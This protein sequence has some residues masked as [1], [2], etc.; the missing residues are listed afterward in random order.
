MTTERI[1]LFAKFKINFSKI[2]PNV[3]DSLIYASGNYIFRFS[4][5]ITNIIVNNLL[6]PVIAGAIAYINAID[7][8]V[9]LLCQPVRSA[10]ER[11]LPVLR[12]DNLSSAIIF[13][14]VSFIMSYLLMI[15]GSSIYLF[16]YLFSQNTY[17]RIVA[18]FFI[19]I[20]IIRSF[21]DLLRI[22]NAALL[23]FKGIS[24]SLIIV[25]LFQPIII[26]SL[27]YIFNLQGLLLGRIVMFIISS[28]LLYRLILVFP[29][30]RFKINLKIVKEIFIL[31]FPLVLN[32]V[33]IV[34]IITVD[35][36]VIKEYI[37]LKELGFYSIGSMIFQ[38]LLI[39]PNSIYGSYFPKFIAK[40]GDQK[41]NIKLL[42]Q[43]VG[44]SCAFIASII[45]YLLHPLFYYILPK[46]IQG[47][48]SAKILVLAFYFAS[49]YQM[50]YYELIRQNKIMTANIFL[51]LIFCLT[52]ILF[53]FTIGFG[54]G[55]QGIAVIMVFI[56]LLMS[57]TLIVIALLKMHEPM[58]DIIK[59]ILS[60]IVYI[61]PLL[62]I[63]TVDFVSSNSS[64]EFQLI[65]YIFLILMFIIF[66]FHLFRNENIISILF[67]R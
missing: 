33:I 42:T 55:I 18:L 4:S 32:S 29:K 63:A 1:K 31:G 50:Y 39:L 21:S 56:F 2:N 40:T 24:I 49:L 8:N 7:Q 59:T 41:K 34:M 47:E 5:A 28:F 14:E 12:K 53:R 11:E 30:L 58:I 19:G 46:F 65:K 35:K 60:S 66:A 3:S 52:L 15:L 10:I 9:D 13:S 51:I 36:I 44:L 6:G 20:N 17:I 25:A 27:T 48:Q 23:N 38:V 67:R 64:F 61:L 16:I 62:G 22:Y 57:V 54:F 43:L 37:G 26:I 45:Y